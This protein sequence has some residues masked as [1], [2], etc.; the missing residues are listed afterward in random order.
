MLSR[1]PAAWL[2]LAR[3]AALLLLTR[4][5]FLLLLTRPA[6]L[7]LL[8]RPASLLLLTRLRR[9]GSAPVRLVAWHDSSPRKW[10]PAEAATARPVRQWWEGRPS[11]ASGADRKCM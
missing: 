7:L 8:T 3:L 4:P 9:P 10:T 5:A 2:R 6:F 11:G 1:R